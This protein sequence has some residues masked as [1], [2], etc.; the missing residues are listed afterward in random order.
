MEWE[1]VMI[2]VFDVHEI[3]SGAGSVAKIDDA[4]YLW[5]TMGIKQISSLCEGIA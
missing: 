2:G 4:S 5:M 1:L 3:Y